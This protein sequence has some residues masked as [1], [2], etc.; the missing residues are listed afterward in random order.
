MMHNTAQY[1]VRYI[2]LGLTVI[3]LSPRTKVPSGKHWTNFTDAQEAKDFFTANPHHN[4]GVNLG[5]SRICSAD[6]DWPEAIEM[7]EAEFGFEFSSLDK[8]HTIEGRA[9]RIMFKVPP[10]MDLPYIKL[11]WRTKDGTNRTVFELRA[12]TPDEQRQDVLPPSIHPDTG[13]AYQWL[14]PPKDGFVEPPEWLLKFWLNFDIIKSQLADFSPWAI[15]Q[16]KPIPSIP[17]QEGDSVSAVFDQ[18]HDIYSTLERYGY[19][20]CGNRYLSPHSQTKMPG[21]HVFEDANKCW[22][23]HASDPL[24]SEDSGHPVGPFDLY[25]QFEFN[26]DYRAATKAA[27]KDL[28]IDHASKN[29]SVQVNNTPA[30]AGQTPI[31]VSALSVDKNGKIINSWTNLH[32]VLSNY[33]VGHDRFLDVPMIQEAGQWRR[34]DDTDYVRFALDIEALGFKTP[35]INMIKDVVRHIM[36]EKSFDSAIDWLDSLTWDGVDRCSR[37]FSVYFGVEPSPYEQAVSEYFVTAMAGR[38]LTPGVQADMVPVLLGGQGI[39]KT[40][41]VKALAPIN[42]SFAE[43]D[44]SGRKDSDLARQLRGKLIGEL[45]ELRG[46]KTKDSEWIKAWIT[47]THEEWTPKFVEH[48]KNMPRRCVFLGTTNEDEF[49]IDV[50]GNRR[51]LPLRVISSCKPAQI[52]NDIDQIWAQAAA[53][54]RKNSVMWE[55]AAGL[56]ESFQEEHTQHDDWAMDSIEEVLNMAQFVS[57]DGFKLKDVTDKL[58]PN[59]EV[60]RASQHRISDALKRLGYIRVTVKK[61]GKFTKAYKKIEDENPFQ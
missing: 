29:V 54:Y 46:L 51:W 5:L 37:L 14:N 61:N 16:T 12:A 24:C 8:Y 50:T 27:A 53:M 35:S 17:R 52:K 39:G 19:T 2:G 49:L 32:I 47:R 59:I 60:S 28:G 42:D 3:P 25:T 9:K 20:R 55:V 45:G 11:N 57:V 15:K 40:S 26:G 23:H 22:I 10:G 38:V 48:S 56:S 6:L 44:L 18:A 33:D 4:L 36:H 30:P 43:I 7:I 41:G 13:N 31:D 1:A 58:F 21:V 34:F